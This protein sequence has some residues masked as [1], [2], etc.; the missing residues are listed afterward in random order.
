MT[1]KAYRFIYGG[2]VHIREAR[3]TRELVDYIKSLI[4]EAERQAERQEA[5]VAEIEEFKI[6]EIEP[7]S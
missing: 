6:E 4:V 7:I 1:T 5:S 3:N 2:R